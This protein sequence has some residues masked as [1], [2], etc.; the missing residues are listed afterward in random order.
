MDDDWEIYSVESFRDNFN[1]CNELFIVNF[2]VRSFN[3]NVDEFIAFVNNLGKIPDIIVLTET[4]FSDIYSE[5][6]DGYVC[7]HSFRSNK[8]G[9]GVSVFI[10]DNMKSVHVVKTISSNI[11]ECCILR[12]FYRNDLIVNL[13]AIYRPPSGYSIGTRKV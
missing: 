5:P 3:A 1:D 11:I 4:W 6:L 8:R 12:I 7:F 9:G 10:R 13:L 2:N